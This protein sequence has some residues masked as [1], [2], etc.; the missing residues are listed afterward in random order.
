[1]TPDDLHGFF[2]ASAGVAGALVGLLFVAVSVTQERLAETGETQIHRVRAD[3]ALT[4]FTNALVISLFALIPGEVIGGT[5]VT[6][7][8]LGLIFC[9]ASLLSVLRVRGVQRRDIRDLLFLGGLGAVFAVQLI[10]GLIV[11]ARPADSGAV[12]AL[13]VL[14]IVCFLIGIARAWELIG[15]PTIGL[16]HEVRAIV[17]GDHSSDSPDPDGPPD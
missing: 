3:A 8:L 6:V 2:E 14:V 15:G 13:A 17:R 9:V 12:D 7:S 4:A 1:V 5:A 10:Y 16:G 11:L